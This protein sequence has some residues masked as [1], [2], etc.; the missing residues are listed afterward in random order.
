MIDLIYCLPNLLFF[1]IP[2]LYYTNLKS[3]IVFVFFLEIYIFPFVNLI[4]FHL[5][6]NCVMKLSLFYLQFYYQLNHQIVVFE[7]VF[8]ACV[9]D[10]LAL[11]RSFWLYLLLKFVTTLVTCA[12]VFLQIFFI[13]RFNWITDLYNSFIIWLLKL[14]SIVD[15]LDL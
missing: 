4:H 6:L 15:Y 2:W 8:I 7:A 9:V 14:R 13:S 5:Y 1:D 12:T 10:F 3:S 11:W